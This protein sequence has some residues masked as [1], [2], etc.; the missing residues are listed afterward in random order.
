M[1]TTE[2]DIQECQKGSRNIINS[3]SQL[4]PDVWK[5]VRDR[6][7]GTVNFLADMNDKNASW[8]DAV[9]SCNQEELEMRTL[10]A[11]AFVA[12]ELAAAKDAGPVDAKAAAARCEAA[13]I[14]RSIR[15]VVLLMHRDHR[16][17]LDAIM[18][19]NR[20]FADQMIAARSAGQ[21]ASDFLAGK[22]EEEVQQLAV[23]SLLF[24]ALDLALVE[25]LQ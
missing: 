8:H 20:G 10:E 15:N 9:V 7:S 11:L 23:E 12:S 2:L 14:Q 25:G 1:S 3:V 24:F 21:F 22:S 13:S 18:Q 16:K 17:T 4:R 6:I 19:R 5:I